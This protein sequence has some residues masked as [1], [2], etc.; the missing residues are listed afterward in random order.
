M[1]FFENSLENKRGKKKTKLMVRE[2]L[3][4]TFFRKLP[5]IMMGCHYES[6]KNWYYFWL[7]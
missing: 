5:S 4:L 1:T 2:N 6:G 3:G 7:F